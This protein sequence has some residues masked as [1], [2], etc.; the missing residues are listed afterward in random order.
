MSS[1]T[2]LVVFLTFRSSDSRPGPVPSSISIR[3][4]RLTYHQ[5]AFVGICGSRV[6]DAEPVV[7]DR[8]V[9]S[10]SHPRTRPRRTANQNWRRVSQNTCRKASSPLSGSRATVFAHQHVTSHSAAPVVSASP[11][12]RICMWGG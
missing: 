4:R 11:S 6:E 7:Q 8:P 12:R 3:P 9:R 2:S 10:L 1:L 5:S